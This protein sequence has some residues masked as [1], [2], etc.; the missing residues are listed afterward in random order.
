MEQV[1]KTKKVEED[2]FEDI[3]IEAFQKGTKPVLPEGM[4]WNPWGNGTTG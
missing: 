4:D 1:G 2:T 3:M